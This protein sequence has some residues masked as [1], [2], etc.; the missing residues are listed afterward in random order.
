MIK[1]TE[2]EY[3]YLKGDKEM[4]PHW[5]AA[6]AVV[7]EFCNNQG[8]GR[9]GEPTKRGVQMMEQYEQEAG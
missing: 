8:L 2:Y 1:L 5:G 6:L 3:G 4:W 7:Y 9:F